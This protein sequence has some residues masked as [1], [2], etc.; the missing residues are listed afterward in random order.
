MRTSELSCLLAAGLIHAAIPV[1]ARVVPRV[2]Q[3]LVADS[4]FRSDDTIEIEVP[5]LPP[6]AQRVPEPEAHAAL[7]TGRLRRV[8]P[9]VPETRPSPSP[10]LSEVP[11]PPDSMPS[12]SPSAE[13]AP[14]GSAR[15]SQDSFDS[16]PEEEGQ[17]FGLPPSLGGGGRAWTMPGLAHSGGGG[18]PA[19]TAPPPPR[20]VDRDV[21]G[22]LLRREMQSQDKAKGIDLPAAGT[23]A[24]TVGSVVREL[25]TPPVSRATFEVR[26]GPSGQV[27]GVRVVSSNAGT[28]DVWARVASAVAAR[29]KGRQ[30]RMTGNYAAGATVYVDMTSLMQMPSGAQGGPQFTGTGATFDLSDIGANGTRVVRTGFRVVPAK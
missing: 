17:G 5:P 2:E 26:L 10:S 9:L 6:E 28:A 27:L 3:P 30:L 19:P 16:L 29:L 12:A 1:V 13:P 7:D 21:A 22:T 25:E 23:V 14:P 4:A 15:P 8:D 20:P 24:S 18:A 11:G